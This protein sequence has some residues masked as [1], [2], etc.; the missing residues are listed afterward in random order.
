MTKQRE[1]RKIASIPEIRARQAEVLHPVYDLAAMSSG[2][3]GQA[4]VVELLEHL[5]EHPE[6]KVQLLRAKRLLGKML[7]A[8]KKAERQRQARRRR[9][10]GT[11]D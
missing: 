4:L 6:D 2:D 8:L 7:Q 1:A 5:A 3:Q 10:R 9:P 11:A